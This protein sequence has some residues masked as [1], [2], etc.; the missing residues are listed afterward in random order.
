MRTTLISATCVA[1][2]LVAYSLTNTQAQ[3]QTPPR[4]AS[5]PSYT[6][7]V[8]VV[9]ITFILDNY[10]RLKQATES[11]KAQVEGMGKQLKAEQEAIMKSGEKLK[12]LKPGSPDFK[13]LEEELA[14]RQSDLKLKASIQEKEFAERESKLYLA[15]YQEVVNTVKTYAE[16]NGIALV[17]RFSGAPIDP[18]NRDAVRAEL[19]KTVMYNS[20]DIDITDPILAELKRNAPPATATRPP[21]AG[22]P[23]APRPQ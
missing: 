14:Q 19:F 4:S 5:P 22:R 7:G 18:N 9:D 13:K 1:T 11:F 17:I 23:A 6:H 8:A 12:A 21:A 15:H 3:Q 2:L 10:P 16:R 20:P